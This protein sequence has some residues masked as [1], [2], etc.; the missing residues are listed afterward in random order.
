MKKTKVIMID[1]FK[2]EYLEYAPYLK[3]LSKNNQY[4]ELDMGVG[5]WRGVDIIFNGN[6][7]IIANFYKN[8]NSLNYF[9]YFIWLDSF[10]KLGKF[11]VNILFNFPRFIKGYEMF[12]INNI[13]LKVLYK[14]DVS[15]K[16]HIAK[17]SDIDFFYFGDLDNLGHEYGTKDSKIIE[18]VKRIDKEISKMEF[19]LIFSDHGMVDIKKIVGVPI[20][21][22]CF[23]DSDMARYWGKEEELEDIIKKLPLNDGKIIKWD[24]KYGD[25]IFLVDTGI[26]IFPNFWNDKP[27]KGMHGYDG[28]NKDMKAFYLLNKT[29][30]KKNLKTEELHQIL[31]EIRKRK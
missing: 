25:L 8:E 5:H 10:G 18:A 24:K 26:L 20:T 6:S 9:K 11:F 1:A 23:I 14:L 27:V 12:K 30:L 3:L 22:D 2:P 7:D 19:D 28:K 15:I 31:N 16:K 13:P 29:G 4:G 21:R 17:K